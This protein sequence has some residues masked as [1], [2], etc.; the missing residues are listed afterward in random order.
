MSNPPDD[1]RQIIVERHFA[2]SPDK[3]WRVLTERHLIA[4]WLM[5]N[6][7]EPKLGHRFSLEAPWGE[8]CAEVL[9][10]EPQRKLAYSWNTKD[11]ESI[12]TWVLVPTESGTVLRM[13]QVGF[14]TRQESY[15]QGA[16]AAWP[17]FLSL[18][19]RIIDRIETAEQLH[20]G[21]KKR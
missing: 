8:V 9:I 5:P 4:D 16:L 12:V 2:C 11:L 14:S 15:Y 20:S 3:L 1:K 7:F 6:D 19:E 18:L 17:R 21:E 10:L 13:E